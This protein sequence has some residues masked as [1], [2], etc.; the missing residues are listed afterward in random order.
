MLIV[1]ED[2]K[3]ER[4]ITAPERSGIMIRRARYLGSTPG[5]I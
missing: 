2:D 3:S 1:S 5:L 4:R